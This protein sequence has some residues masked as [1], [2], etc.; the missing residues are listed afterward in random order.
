MLLGHLGEQLLQPG[1]QPL[2]V[3][4]ALGQDA[5]VYKDLPDVVQALVL[6]ELIEKLVGD[7]AILTG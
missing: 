4:E 6:R 3:F 5:S 1:A 2:Q 7:R